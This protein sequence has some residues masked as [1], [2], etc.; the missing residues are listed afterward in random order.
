MYSRN[1]LFRR[2]RE[3]SIFYYL[4]QK[5][6]GAVCFH[7]AILLGFCQNDV[8]FCFSV[9][10]P[11]VFYTESLIQNPDTL[12]LYSHRVYAHNIISS[13]HI[14]GNRFYMNNTDIFT[15]CLPKSATL[16]THLILPPLLLFLQALVLRISSSVHKHTPHG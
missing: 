3:Y 5:I 14:T 12:L 8:P 16:F 13:I 6:V 11:K 10:I 2:S 7:E 9:F 4:F 1:F 15:L